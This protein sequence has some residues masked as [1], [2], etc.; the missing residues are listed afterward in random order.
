MQSSIQSCRDGEASTFTANF[1]FTTCREGSYKKN[2]K[3]PYACTCTW[4]KVMCVF[5]I[6][7]FKY[8]DNLWTKRGYSLVTVL[9]FAELVAK[10]ALIH[11][12]SGFLSLVVWLILCSFVCPCS[13]THRA[14]VHL[15]T[16][17]G[18]ARVLYI[19][20]V[21]AKTHLQGFLRHDMLSVSE[22][23]LD[24]YAGSQTQ[25]DTDWFVLIV[26]GPWGELLVHGECV[27]KHQRCLNAIAM[28]GLWPLQQLEVEMYP[29]AC[30]QPQSQFF[31]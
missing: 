15:N 26:V 31:A 3:R 5:E 20:L 24:L 21:R 30:P 11:V 19:S 25:L 6:P 10:P 7:V 13:F 23:S 8:I 22:K 27:K 12:F 16:D 14:S 4:C 9:W 2:V 1:S 17:F 29:Q 28:A 18:R